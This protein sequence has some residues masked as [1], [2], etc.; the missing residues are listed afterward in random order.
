MDQTALIVATAAEKKG[1]QEL[2]NGH[3]GQEQLVSDT[4]ALALQ[5]VK[6]KWD[7]RA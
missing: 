6:T 1:E 5:L 4:L 7:V 2:L 3:V